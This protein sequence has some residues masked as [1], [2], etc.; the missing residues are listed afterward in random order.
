M[1]TN[2]T[3]RVYLRA[4]PG[5]GYVAIETMPVRTLV[6]QRRYRGAVILERRTNVNRRA[7]HQPPVIALAEA[8]S[9]ATILD[10]LFPLTQSNAALAAECLCQTRS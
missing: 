6:G 10:K 5:G 7:G 3:E 9:V 1:R 8:S 4:L 2:T